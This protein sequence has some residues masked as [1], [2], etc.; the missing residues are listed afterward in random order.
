MSYPLTLQPLVIE[1]D[2]GAKDAY[3]GIFEAI[4]ADYGDLPFAPAPP[5]F[6]FSYEEA[7]EYL[8]GSKIFH[9]VILDLRLP[10]KPKLPPIDGTE[11][12]L[13]L[14]TLCVDRDHYP[15]PGATSDKWPHRFN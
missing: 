12:G 9:V 13:K 11:L 10:E 3:K 1:D 15:I 8:D 4:A 14:L 7:K 2:E 5:C 6:A